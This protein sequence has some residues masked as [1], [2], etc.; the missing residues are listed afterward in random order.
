MRKRWILAPGLL[1]LF[2]AATACSFST[3]NLSSLKIG[4]VKGVA[5]ES[6]SFGASD[7]IYAIAEVSNAPGS[8]KV[9]GRLAIE[10]VEGQQSGPIPGLE[11]TLELPGSGT[12]D[13]TFTPPPAGWPKGKYKMEVLMMNESGEQK[14]QKSASFTVS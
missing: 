11:K 1:L 10:D 2:V 7:A 6:N 3:A 4:K 12:A 9:T 5:Q 14:D 8:L 13:F